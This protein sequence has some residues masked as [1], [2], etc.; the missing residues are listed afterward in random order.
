MSDNLI[1]DNKE[2]PITLEKIAGDVAE[3]MDQARMEQEGA[4]S[5]QGNDAQPVE[6]VP[7]AGNKPANVPAKFWDAQSN[8]IRIGAL[9]Q[10]YSELERKLS[11]SMPKPETDEDRMAVLRMLGMPESPDGYEVD[12]SHGLFD[13][14]DDLNGKLFDNGFT[15]EQVQAVY[16]LAAD[17]FVPMVFEI[18]QEFHADREVER[19]ISAFGGKEKWQEV[20][21]QLLTY[22][23]QNLPPEVLDSLAGSFEGV[24]ALYRMM[25]GDEPVMSK[26]GGDAGSNAGDED[27]LHSLMR[28]PKYWKDKDPAFVSKVT[29]GFQRLYNEG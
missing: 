4:L 19:L 13:V 11:G 12:V 28:D 23:K 18:A 5:P 9:V 7:V 16:D 15:L 14:D 17:K 21:R 27:E 3:K 8:A 1:E 6:D 25:K 10:S 26:H 29:K 22:G 24:M 2:N 20:S